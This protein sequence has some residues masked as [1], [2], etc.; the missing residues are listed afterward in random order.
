MSGLGM[1]SQESPAVKWYLKQ[2]VCTEIS[3]GEGWMEMRKGACR[4]SQARPQLELEPSKE[5]E[6]GEDSPKEKLGK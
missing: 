1:S 6:P 2:L 4:E 5:E 3:L